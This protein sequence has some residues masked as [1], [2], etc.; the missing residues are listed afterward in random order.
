MNFWNL[1]TLLGMLLPIPSVWFHPPMDTVD[2]FS[3]ER[4]QGNWYEIARN[5]MAQKAFEKDCVCNHD[6]Y[7]LQHD[8]FYDI[9]YFNVRHYCRKGSVCKFS[10]TV[11][12]S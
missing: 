1:I 7:E 10:I 2:E 4:Y 11:N 6:D 3:P 8:S 12:S 5:K 9:T